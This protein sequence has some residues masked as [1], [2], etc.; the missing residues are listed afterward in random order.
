MASE[1]ARLEA[2]NE[3]GHELKA[4]DLCHVRTTTAARAIT[5][6]AGQVPTAACRVQRLRLQG[7]LRSAAGSSAA[8][9]PHR[10]AKTIRQ[11]RCHLAQA[12]ME[13]ATALEAEGSVSHPMRSRW[14]S[15][16]LHASGN[17]CR[18][19]PAE[20]PAASWLVRPAIVRQQARRSSVCH[21]PG[22]TAVF[23]GLH[24]SQQP[25]RLPQLRRRRQH[26]RG[27]SARQA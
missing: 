27:R 3:Q 2:H 26:I 8:V 12:V 13:A 14:Y 21:R 25:V 16:T 15:R 9:H 22:P 6:H 19:C 7:L 24:P 23:L 10:T 20:L 11:V 1:P 17:A 18:H 4:C 5:I